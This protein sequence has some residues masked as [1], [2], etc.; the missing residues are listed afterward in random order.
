[1]E[2]N[3]TEGYITRVYSGLSKC[4]SGILQFDISSNGLLAAGDDHLIKVW[5]ADND[6]ILTVIDAGGDLT[7]CIE[8]WL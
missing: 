1:M 5:N 8:F 3:E 2:W 4:F 7:V 6:Q